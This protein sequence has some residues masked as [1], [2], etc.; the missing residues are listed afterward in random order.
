MTEPRL[1]H[2]MVFCKDVPKLARFYEAAFDLWQW[3]GT[4]FCE[5]ADPEGNVIQIFR[6]PP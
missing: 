6:S 5:C 4:R 2:V 3:E 1:R